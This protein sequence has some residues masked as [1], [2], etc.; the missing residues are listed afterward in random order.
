[1][2]DRT[3][4]PATDRAAPTG[5]STTGTTPIP[6][7]D[8]APAPTA[9][10]SRGTQVAM[11]VLVTAAIAL[12]VWINYRQGWKNLDAWIGLVE[13]AIMGTIGAVYP[14]YRRAKSNIGPIFMLW[15]GGVAAALVA[16]VSGPLKD[17]VFQGAAGAVPK[18]TGTNLGFYIVY[19]LIGSAVLDGFLEIKDWRQVAQYLAE[20]PG[21]KNAAAAVAGSR[22]GAEALTALG[23]RNS[24]LNGNATFDGT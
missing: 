21:S 20:Q 24:T 5:G 1:M 10:L 8:P 12:L 17:V 2:T 11:T 15:V 9:K 3:D 18:V 4:A 14:A 23:T 7:T 22:T 6:P 19:G 16:L 13:A